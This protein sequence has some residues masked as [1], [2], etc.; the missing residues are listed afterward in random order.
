MIGDSMPRVCCGGS[1]RSVT[2][3]SRLTFWGTSIPSF[4][5]Q[6]FVFRPSRKSRA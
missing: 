1:W 2:W 6:F 4:R 5:D 3:S